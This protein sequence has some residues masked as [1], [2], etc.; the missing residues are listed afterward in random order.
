MLPFAILSTTA[1]ASALM[2][3]SASVKMRHGCD[4]TLRITE[5]AHSTAYAHAPLLGTGVAE[6]HPV[7]RNLMVRIVIVA[8]PSV[9][10]V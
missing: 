8:G 1:F 2:E 10:N 4:P 9:A 6:D 3:S 7:E 5:M